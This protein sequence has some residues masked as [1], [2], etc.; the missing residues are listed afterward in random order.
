MEMHFV[1]ACYEATQRILC[2]AEAIVD[3][4][5]NCLFA[6]RAADK[7]A[8]RAEDERALASGE[9]SR[10]E[11]RRENG[12]FAGLADAPILWAEVGSLY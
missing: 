5:K 7:A 4:K 9:K 10:E 8:S 3:P 6:Q 11:L 1:L 2:K 12:H